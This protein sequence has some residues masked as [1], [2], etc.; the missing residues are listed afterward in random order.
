MKAATL[1]QSASRIPEPAPY[2]LDGLTKTSTR[3]MAVLVGL[4]F[5]VATFA[6]AIG[7]ALIDSHF[8]SGTSRDGTLVSASSFSPAPA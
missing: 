3:K 5:L 2:A 4:C 6:F 1:N 7:S 8:S